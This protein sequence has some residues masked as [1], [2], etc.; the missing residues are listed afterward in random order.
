MTV[1]FV[2][3]LL[4]RVV[5]TRYPQRPEPSVTTLPTPPRFRADSLTADLVDRM[6]AV[7]PGGALRRAGNDLVYD[8][9]ACTACARCYPIAGAAA[10]PSGVLE[11]AATARTQLVKHIPIPPEDTR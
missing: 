10:R 7:C 3:G 1:W 9:G 4:R 2:R 5:T 11:L 6:V 8:V